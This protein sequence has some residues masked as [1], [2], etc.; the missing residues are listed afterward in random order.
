MYRIDYPIRPGVTRIAVMYKVPYATGSY[1]L[2]EK[3]L[4]P[5]SHVTVFAVDSTM[6]ITSASHEFQSQQSVHGMTAYSVHDV[7]AN[8]ELVLTFAG[9]DAGF[10]GLDVERDANHPTPGDHV[11]VA[12]GEDEKLSY[13][14][15]ATVLL[16]LAGIIGMSLR[17]RNDPLSDPKILRAHY[18]TLLSRLVRLDDLHAAQ[19]IP[20]DAYRASREELIGRLAALAM[21][22]RAHG[23]VHAPDGSE[24]PSARSKVQ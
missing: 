22:L 7:A 1:T 13:F 21:Q 6:T 4:H 15:M 11:V 24:A 18:S 2:R 9:G 10:A 14:L 17:D 19:A 16:V 3:M 12:S 23:G 5:V 20:S 8:G